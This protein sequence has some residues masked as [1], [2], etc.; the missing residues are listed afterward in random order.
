MINKAWEDLIS[1]NTWKHDASDVE[2]LSKA[3]TWIDSDNHGT[4]WHSF[5]LPIEKAFEKDKAPL[6]ITKDREGYY[7][8]HHFSYWASGLRDMKNLLDCAAKYE[9]NVE[10]YLDFGCASGRILRH[11]LYNSNIMELYGVD[12]NRSHIDWINFNL[13]NGIIA[14][15]NTSIPYIQLPDSSVDLI[16]AY[17]V[18]THI[19]AFE[20]AWLMELNRII[21]PNGLAWITIHS[22]KTWM[23]IDDSWP[24]FNALKNHPDY[25]KIEDKTIM[26]GDRLVFR[27]HNDSSYSSNVFYS[28]DYI[29]SVWG[30]IFEIVEIKRRFPEYQDVIILKPKRV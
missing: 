28:F 25:K 22:D 5:D 8:D 16:S 23:E 26:S 21:K 6:P 13:D 30:R 20:T 19:E 15:Q 12:I 3:S 9:V 1:L 27:W 29:K 10:S 17:S 11:F 18:F 4:D 2:L 7:G 14:F 24:L